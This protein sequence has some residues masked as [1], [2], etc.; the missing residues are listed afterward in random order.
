M[1][2]NIR[3]YNLWSIFV[4]EITWFSTIFH[5]SPTALDEA[6]HLMDYFDKPFVTHTMLSQPF[7]S[8]FQSFNKLYVNKTKPSKQYRSCLSSEITLK[9]TIN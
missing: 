5:T 7:M 2:K 4:I 8:A 6:Q 3:N 1:D 9:S